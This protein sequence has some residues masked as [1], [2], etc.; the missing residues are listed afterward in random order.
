MYLLCGFCL[1]AVNNLRQGRHVY[2]CKRY[3]LDECGVGV[4]ISEQTSGQKS[5]KARQHTDEIHTKA[6]FSV[7]SRR[8]NAQLLLL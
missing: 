4:N 8:Q 7:F 2:L 5:G 1:R 6:P 3:I